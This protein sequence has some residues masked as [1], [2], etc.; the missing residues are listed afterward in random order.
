MDTSPMISTDESFIGHG[1]TTRPHALKV[2][3]TIVYSDGTRAVVTKIPGPTRYEYRI[4]PPPW[5]ERCLRWAFVG[6]VAAFAGIG[7]A[8]VILSL[9]SLLG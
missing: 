7:A 1:V 9:V 6:L 4:L 5:W 3:D 8:A 2:G